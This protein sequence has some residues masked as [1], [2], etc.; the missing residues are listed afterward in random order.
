MYL[1]VYYILTYG[2][3]CIANIIVGKIKGRTWAEEWG[4][5]FCAG[6]IVGEA[7]LQLGI[8]SIVLLAG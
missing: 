7:I 1:P 6:L 3:G 8:N 2:I 5:P 4:V